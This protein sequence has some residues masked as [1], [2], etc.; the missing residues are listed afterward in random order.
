[1][2]LPVLT[3]LLTILAGSAAAADRPNIL[4]LVSEDNVSTTVGAYGDSLDLTQ[5]DIARWL[6]AYNRAASAWD[7]NS[8][9][10]RLNRGEAVRPSPVLADLLVVTEALRTATDSVVEPALEPVLAAWGFS[11]GENLLPTSSFSFQIFNIVN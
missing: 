8:E 3:I 6:D 4:W 1:M 5:D 7:P 9:L 11:V 2:R 10:S